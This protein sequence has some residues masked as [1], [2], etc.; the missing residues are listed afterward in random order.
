[1]SDAGQLAY[2]VRRM[3]YRH[4]RLDAAALNDLE[5]MA[6]EGRCRGRCG[7][8]AGHD[9]YCRNCRPV[10]DCQVW[11]IGPDGIEPPTCAPGPSGVCCM[12]EEPA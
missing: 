3:F 8:F 7:C 1:M 4:N 11:N 5:K 10:R 9:G 6:A 12:D 2:R